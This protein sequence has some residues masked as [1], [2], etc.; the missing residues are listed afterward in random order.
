MSHERF[1]TLLVVIA[2]SAPQLTVLAADVPFDNDLGNNNWNLASNWDGNLLPS[3]SDRA[4]VNNGLTA[5]I[6]ANSVFTPLEV[7]VGN[8]DLGGTLNIAANLSAGGLG[9]AVSGS[10]GGVITQASGI[11]SLGGGGTGAL[12]I[13]SSNPF[14]G[15]G[16]YTISGGALNFVD[17]IVGVEGPGI[18]RV[19]GSSATQIQGSTLDLGSQSQLHF[20]LG[21]SG[22]TP[23]VLTQDTSVLPPI[24]GG[25]NI[26]AG[27]SLVIDGSAY[28]GG[29][30]TIPLI[31]SLGDG[32]DLFSSANV[33]FV[34]LN[35]LN[36]TI[37]QKNN[38]VYLVLGQGSDLFPG[39]KVSDAAPTQNVLISQ[40]SGGSEPAGVRNITTGS[41]PFQNNIHQVVGQS[42]KNDAPFKLDA[43]TFKIAVNQ[44]EI[45]DGAVMN[46]YVT[47]DTNGD[48]VPDTS[49]ASQSFD[50]SGLDFSP[51]DYV[52]FDFN[53]ATEQAIGML[54]AN[55]AYAVELDFAA[56]GL[57]FYGD[58]QIFFDT[59]RGG[60]AYSDG[61]LV[62]RD[63]PTSVP[64]FSLA[65][66]DLDFQFYVQGQV[67][68]SVPGDYNGNGTV[69]AADYTIWRDT[70]GSITD[71]RADGNGDHMV[72][73]DDYTYWK[74]RF[75]NTSGSGNLGLPYTVPEPTSSGLCLI[76]L[77][78]YSSLASRRRRLSAYR[79]SYRRCQP[80]DSLRDC[81]AVVAGNG[82]K[83][84]RR[85]CR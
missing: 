73:A 16:R 28:T 85:I 18:F 43:I 24:G 31:R 39:I 40:Q 54:A 68:L 76:G 21:T 52:T 72:N 50:V 7:F 33:S 23:I 60:D 6:N 11:V 67:Q 2:A 36:P 74:T 84:L 49:V 57:G 64:T 17:M 53:P 70:L 42:F 81:R 82:L 14:L 20:L 13:A 77:M 30:A 1:L 83:C 37:Q 63:S 79:N 15:T 38:D 4:I 12:N 45:L 78:A 58:R 48:N 41:P 3:S 75:G 62:F 44:G 22:V 26:A 51:S 5:N 59:S 61:Q 55:T 27:A 34:G 10:A 47:A 69:D 71:F 66:P 8:D 65:G 29:S 32:G 19:E 25:I 56:S 9:V 80:T 46:V 35:A